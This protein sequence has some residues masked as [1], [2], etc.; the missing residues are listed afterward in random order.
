MKRKIITI[1]VT[2]IFLISIPVSML[3]FGFCLPAQY[4]N[5]YYAV[6]P[7]M[8]HK[9]KT[10][11][12]KKIIFIGN[13]AVAF[14]LDPDI[15]KKEIDGY[16][17]CPFG[18][19]GAIG[20]KAMMDLSR[21]N[22][23]E[24]DIVLLLPEQ[25]QQSMSLYF[26]GEYVWNAADGDFGLLKYIKNGGEMAG[27][28]TGYVSR[29]FKY[30]NAGAA[31]TSTDVYA[32]SSFDGEC[33]MVYDRP[34]NKLPS[35][36]DAMSRISY[37]TDIFS[38][39]FAE[40]VNEFNRFVESRGATLLFGFSPV[41][42]LSLELGTT[43][44]DI[45]S[46]YDYIASLLDCQ[47]L[48]N[49]HEYIF[50][51]DWFYDSNVHMNTSGSIVYTRQLVKDLK[52]F[53][54]DSTP[55]AAQIPPM[56]EIPDDMETGE[57]GKDAAL[58][59]YESEG[60]GWKITSLRAEGASRTSIEIPDFYQGKKVLCFSSSVFSGNTTIEEIY[61]GKNIYGIEDNSFSGCKN[62]KGLYLPREGEPSDCTVYFA[63][64]EGAPACTVYVPQEKL[65]SYANDY[66][67]SRY[68]AY[69]ARY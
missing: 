28:F 67:W 47:I 3:L 22:I 26:N 10:T 66:F 21:V 55:I 57:D 69:L 6:L 51:S 37:D 58:F 54:G 27:G 17:A 23:R 49:P 33:K 11:E 14:G 39:D 8:F 53:L 30:Y 32:S 64:L 34:Y 59:T 36:Y 56:P 35:G 42:A 16:S 25:M 15:V 43:V 2:F 62:L 40:Y 38:C 52:V 31:P 46:F 4:G 50:E 48:G 18:L 24:D 1:I 44:E 60:N 65:S 29:K 41:N 61:I 7:K 45:D 20:T 5:T 9:L 68:G 13:S 19:Y 12:G 63:L